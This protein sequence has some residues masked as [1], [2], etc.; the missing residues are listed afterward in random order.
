MD[1]LLVRLSGEHATLPRAE[2]HALLDVHAPD[3]AVAEVHPT[4]VR[5]HGG[6]IDA[7]LN[8]MALAHATATHWGSG[9]LETVTQIVADRADGAG[10]VAVRCDR[11]G[12][13]A[14]WRRMEVERTLGAALAASGHAI[15]LVAPDRTMVAW[16]HG[17][18]IAVGELCRDTDRARFTRRHV[19]DRDHFSP[20]GMHPRR[21]ASLLHLARVPQGGTVLDP[22]CGTGGIVLEAALDG[23]HAVGSDIDPWMV[24]GTLQALADAGPKPLDGTVFQADVGDVAH[25]LHPVDGIVTDLPYGRASTTEGEGVGPL[26]DRAFAV[27]AQLLPAGRYAVIG[28]ADDALG[29]RIAEHGFDVTEHHAEYVHGSMTRHYLVARRR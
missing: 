22:F 16:M 2:L 23:C 6:G 20:V 19:T 4:V 13:D 28:C 11:D 1:G 27:F 9:D 7:A 12:H 26:Y 29:Q 18:T 15:D 10:S 14:G 8:R 17:D 24:Q 21:A 5:V 3:A 25:L